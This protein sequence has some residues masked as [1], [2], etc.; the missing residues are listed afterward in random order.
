METDVADLRFVECT[1]D[2]DSSHPVTLQTLQNGFRGSVDTQP[3]LRL[4]IPM[5]CF[6][7]LYFSS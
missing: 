7:W 6:D 4:C 2:I 3:K 1:G 5:D